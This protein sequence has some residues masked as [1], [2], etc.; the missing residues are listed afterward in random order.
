METTPAIPAYMAMGS[1][2]SE[3][4]IPAKSDGDAVTVTFLTEY[5]T[6]MGGSMMN[7]KE[8]DKATVARSR[9]EAWQKRGIVSMEGGK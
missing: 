3:M 7:Y 9:A 2:I 1:E 5:S 8:G 4:A 6:D